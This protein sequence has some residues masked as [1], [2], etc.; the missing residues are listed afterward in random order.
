MTQTQVEILTAALER[1]V[2]EC[3]D[4]SRVGTPTFWDMEEDVRLKFTLMARAA[5]EALTE[6]GKDRER[7][8]KH[9]GEWSFDPP[10]DVGCYWMRSPNDR[11]HPWTRDWVQIS[12]DDPSRITQ[13]GTY[14][15]YSL[16]VEEP[17]I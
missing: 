1:V 16:K 3:R 15:F 11:R 17:L 2:G 9:R 12:I 8:V 7:A 13:T 5:E 4:V 14:E 6:S 10:T